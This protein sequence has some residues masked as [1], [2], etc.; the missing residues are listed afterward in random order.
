MPQ[1]RAEAYRKALAAFDEA[2]KAGD[3]G[4]ALDAM[5]ALQALEDED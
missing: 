4:A 2:T 3:K 1:D 5:D